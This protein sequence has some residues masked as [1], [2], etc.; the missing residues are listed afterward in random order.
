MRT[1]YFLALVL[2]LLVAGCTTS[3]SNQGLNQQNSQHSNDYL[4]NL[5]SEEISGDEKEALI[6]TLND[7]FKAEAT[8]QK[9]MDKFG[10]IRPFSNII[11]AEQ[12]HSDSLIVLFN[13][14]DLKIPENDWYEKVSEFDSIQEAC[15]AGVEA[16]IENVGLYDEMFSKVDNQDIIQVFTS[17]RAA[18]Q[19]KHLPAFERCN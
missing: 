19:E 6:A 16:E 13:K 9:V 8:Y 10:E 17:L 18:S 1:I 3:G 14:Y 12:R 4:D 15:Q 2:M 11:N 5:P 7:E